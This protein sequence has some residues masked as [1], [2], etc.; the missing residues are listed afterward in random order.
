M[1]SNLIK[2]ENDLYDIAA[3]LRSLRDG[4]VVFYNVDTRKYEVHDLSQHGSTLAFVVPFDELDSRT[5]DYAQMTAARN[6]DKILA[7]IESNNAQLDKQRLSNSVD[8]AMEQY[9]ERR[10]YD[11]C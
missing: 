3:R 2:I 6:A 7:E 4:Y 1:K 8:K 11:R 10:F 9:Q 5:V